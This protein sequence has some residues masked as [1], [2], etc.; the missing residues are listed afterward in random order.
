M[1]DITGGI[2]AG[3]K[4]SRL[5]G[6]DKGWVEWQG[7]PLV[8]HVI[9]R[10]KPQVETLVINCNRNHERYASLGYSIIEDQRTGFQGP[11]AGIAA[12]LSRCET[13]WLL[14][15]PCDGPHLP[16]DLAERLHHAATH[17]NTP[18]SI[19]EDAEFIQPM[20]ALI[21]TSLASNLEAFLQ[22]GNRKPMQWYK[23]QGLTVVDFGDQSKAFFNINRP[24]Q[25][26]AATT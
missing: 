8:H 24:E 3:G 23:Q 25:M 4:G 17:K 26:N 15:C 20:H 5:G 11:L 6:Q 7:K 10:L 16:V 9:K 19:A 12:L 13:D 14:I 21:H 1:N 2:L 22:S 18:V